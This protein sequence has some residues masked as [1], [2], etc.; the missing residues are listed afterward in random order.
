MDYTVV[1]KVSYRDHGD[2]SDTVKQVELGDIE[3]DSKE[4]IGKVAEIITGQLK[5]REGLH[6]RGF[7]DK[8]TYPTDTEFYLYTGLDK[9][10]EFSRMYKIEL[11]DCIKIKG[12]LFVLTPF[13]LHE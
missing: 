1:A 8:D 13:S 3:I 9:E 11:V 2:Y 6:Y 7:T 5:I 4:A 12:R 10:W